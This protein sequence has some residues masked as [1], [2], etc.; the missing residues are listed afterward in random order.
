MSLHEV[1]YK[2][3][4]NSP[5]AIRELRENTAW[6]VSLLQLSSGR[7]LVVSKNAR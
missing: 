1:Q 4:V 2:L 6:K 7:R 3:E 5:E